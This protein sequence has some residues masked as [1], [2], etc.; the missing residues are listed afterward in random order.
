MPRKQRARAP[1]A[2]RSISH[3]PHLSPTRPWWHDLR[4]LRE[5]FGLT[6]S[7]LA[8]KAGTSPSSLSAIEYRKRIPRAALRGELIQ[9]FRD[10]YKKMGEAGWYFTPQTAALVAKVFVRMPEE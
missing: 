2:P 10:A 5:A 7:E 8:R 9:I 3:T 6:L 4:K 1:A